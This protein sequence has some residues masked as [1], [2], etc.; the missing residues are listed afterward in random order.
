[1]FIPAG[2]A[3]LV[4]VRV[5]GDW[6]GE[7]FVDSMLPEEQNPGTFYHL[8]GKEPLIFV[9][10]HSYEGVEVSMKK[11]LGT[12]HSLDI[13]KKAWLKD[14]LRGRSETE[15]GKDAEENL[16]E[17]VYGMKESDYPTEKSKRK[18]I[19][20]SFKINDNKILNKDENLM[21]EEVIKTFIDN[22][23]ALALLNNHDGKT[24]LVE[25]KLNLEPGTVP[26][27]SKVRLLNPDQKRNLKDQI[28]EWIE[29]GAIGPANS[30]WASPCVPVKKT[31]ERT[32]RA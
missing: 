26:K 16:S 30:P 1:M 15:V 18:F 29:K 3:K 31:N 13:D 4:K 27:R 28:D 10:N 7:G 8:S 24:D 5:E 19:S 23:L 14:Q 21:K 6:R 32:F 11:R 22:F 20:E 17:N 9:E 25:L 12:I 2:S